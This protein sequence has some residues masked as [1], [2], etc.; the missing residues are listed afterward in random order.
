MADTDVAPE[1]DTESIPV[2]A[3][4]S[5]AGTSHLTQ[6]ENTDVT[7]APVEPETDRS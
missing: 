5:K 6:G 1:S 4:G 3:D 2:R 7:Q